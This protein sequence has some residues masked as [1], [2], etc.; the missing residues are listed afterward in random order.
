MP[1]VN[2][3]VDTDLRYFQVT[4]QG[5]F[6]ELRADK[7]DRVEIR[8]EQ[9]V[10]RLSKAVEWLL[11]DSGAI[12]TVSKE[13]TAYNLFGSFIKTTYGGKIY[14]ELPGIEIESKLE[15]EGKIRCQK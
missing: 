12:P 4:R 13:S 10:A 2:V 14:K 11:A 8:S 9:E 1:E 6:V 5:I 7:E 3:T 15:F